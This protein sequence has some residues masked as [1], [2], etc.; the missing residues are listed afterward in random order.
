MSV[1]LVLGSRVVGYAAVALALLLVSPGKAEGTETST[2]RGEVE[3]ADYDEDG[4]VTEV[5][6][7][8]DEWGSVLV[9]A[10]GKG[11]E[12]LDQIGAVVSATGEIR[13]L[14]GD[15]GYSY[16]IEV[17]SYTIDEPAEPEGG[18]EDD[19]DN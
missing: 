9:L 12:L 15:R 14:D 8:D 6:I 17:T 5:A 4:A 1:K 19:P 3:V 7:Y 16:A 2:I 11:S 18:L 13:E 10:S